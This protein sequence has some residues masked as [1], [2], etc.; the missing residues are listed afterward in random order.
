MLSWS[1]PKR[2]SSGAKI[3]RG[4]RPGRPGLSLLNQ[5]VLEL[6]MARCA[7]SLLR[8]GGVSLRPQPTK[9]PPK[10]RAAQA[11]GI[12]RRPR[13]SQGALPGP[14]LL[15]QR[16]RGEL[17]VAELEE[18]SLECTEYDRHTVSLLDENTRLRAGLGEE[19]AQAR[20]LLATQVTHT[21][22]RTHTH[23]HARTLNSAL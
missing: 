3:G 9:A 20:R 7:R 4:L 14:T 11:N 13:R 15:M 18:A 22:V 21:H 2:R 17:T 23:I 12:H 1:A 10:A 6:V 16:L 5:N 19:V 8:S